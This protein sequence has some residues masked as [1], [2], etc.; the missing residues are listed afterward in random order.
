MYLTLA[1]GKF[2][3]F[4]KSLKVRKL[5]LALLVIASAVVS[6]SQGMGDL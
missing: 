4:A 3:I 5:L 6:S 1:L 2:L